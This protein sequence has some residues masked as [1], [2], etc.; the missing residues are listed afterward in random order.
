MNREYATQII[1]KL[2]EYGVAEFYVCA[3]ARNIP[4]VEVLLQIEHAKKIVFNHFEERSAAFYAL[5]RI[6]QIAKPVAVITTSGTAVGELLPAVMEAYHAGLPLVMLTAD[7]PKS[8]RHCGAPQTTN[9]KNIFN[10][11]VFLGH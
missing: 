9:Q 1:T 6:K 2:L 7:R 4:I 5:G 10:A 8:Q 11:L 3:G